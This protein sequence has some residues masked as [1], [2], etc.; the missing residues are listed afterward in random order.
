MAEGSRQAFETLVQP[1]V[2]ALYRT[3]LRM[4]GNS[5][6]AEDL[7]QDAC[8]KAYAS[9]GRFQPGSNFKAWVFRILTNA[10]VDG[11]R[12]RARTPL[13]DMETDLVEQIG[14]DAVSRPNPEVHVLY[15]TFRSEAFKAMAALPAD[16]RIVVA[17]S[18]L[19]QFTYQEIADVV[20]CPVG[21]VRS[22]LSRGRQSLQAV[23]GPFVPEDAGLS[24]LGTESA[25]ETR[26]PARG[27][28]GDTHE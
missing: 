1:C 22:R 25:K 7:V 14:G 4:T 9:F 3:A 21:T 27:K 23:L 28:S 26:V 12:K 19:E 17:L 10:F 13:V 16:V 20:G 5:H 15:R 2:D 6:A 18:L 8:L 11:E 24:E